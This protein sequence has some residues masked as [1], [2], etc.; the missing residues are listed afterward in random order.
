MKKLLLFVFLLSA[1]SSYAQ[2]EVILQDANAKEVPLNASFNAVHVATGIQLILVQSNTNK[3]AISVP[4]E[5]YLK[6]LVTKVEN[7]ELKIYFD[8]KNL[9]GLFAKN[10]R[11][12]AYVSVASLKKLRGSSGASISMVNVFNE[13][14]LDIDL[15]SGA[16]M[17]G[18]LKVGTLNI[19]VSSGAKLDINGQSGNADLSASSGAKIDGSDL[20][21]TDCKAKASSGGKI[22]VAVVKSLDGKA[23]SGGKVEYSGNAIQINAETSSGGKVEKS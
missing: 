20:S 10:N 15:S 7:G 17:V 16:K 11:V 8:Y 9:D 22:S 13:E 19:D 12:K 14:S 2:K 5:K 23:S 3:L 1:F 6:H 18:K 4:D 21:V